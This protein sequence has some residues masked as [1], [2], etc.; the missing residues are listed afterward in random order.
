MEKHID[1]YFTSLS[2]YTYLGHT[3]F[4][5]MMQENDVSIAFKPVILG[6][7][8][9]DSGALPLPQRPKSRQTY[10]LVEIERWA[11]KRQ[12]PIVMH[13]AYFPTDPSLAD[14][15]IIVLQQDGKDVSNLVARLLSA[16]WAEEK[17]IADESLIETVLSELGFDSQEV[18]AKAK[19]DLAQ[20][21]YERNTEEAIEKG[22]LGAPSYVYNNEQFWGQDRLELLRDAI[23]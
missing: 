7:I 3:L 8:F 18:I 10:R 23:R 9:A 12:L 1:Y 22:V 20:A 11:K 14:K 17:N 19:S 15:C 5:T 16:C 13:P 4:L 2:P 21:L 6:K